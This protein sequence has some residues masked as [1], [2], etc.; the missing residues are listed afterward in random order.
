ML[1]AS[2]ASAQTVS[3]ALTFGQNNFYG[4]ARTLAMGNAVTAV[5]GDM[6][7]ISIN[8]AGGAVSAFSQFSFSTGWSTSRSSSSYAPSYDPTSQSAVYDGRFENSKTRMTIPNI[9][10]NLY[11]ETGERSG[12][13]G[14]NFGFM[15]NR[16]QTYTSKMGASGLEGH[17]S[18][19]GALACGADGM[20]GNILGNNNMF[21]TD[22]PW[23]SICAYDGG[24]I[25][26]NSDAGTYYGSAETVTPPATPADDYR[27]EVLGTLRQNI[28]TTTLGSKNDLVMNYGVNIDDRLF[29]GLSMNCPIVSYKYSEYFNEAV[30]DPDEFKITTEYFDKTANAYVKGNPTSYTG[31]TYKYNYIADVS[32]INLKIGAIW[33]PTDGLRLGAAFQ[34]PTGYTINETWYVDVESRFLDAAQNANSSSPTAKSSYSYRAP[35][36]ANFG[37]AYT[38][39]RNGMLSVDYELTDY[40]IMKFSM[41]EGDEYVYSDP[42]YA[43]NK[44]NKLF[45]GVSHALRV[46]AEFRVLPSVS[47]RAGLN[48]VTSAERHYTNS[49]G[50][51]VYVADYDAF[52]NDYQNGTLSI[53]KSTAEY[54]DDKLFTLSCGIGYSSPGSFY[55]DLA[56]RHS[57]LP[58][59]YYR[60]YS[61]YLNIVSPAVRSKHTLFDAVMTF[62]WRF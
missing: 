29:L 45:C 2:L 53:D 10:M 25:N 34:T 46:G 32:G 23:N 60:P 42:F 4:T 8:P 15:V 36:S 54:S 44:L 26:F 33:L 14:W 9:G 43:V 30:Q 38:L 12:V 58:D 61:N 18:M 3:D 59:S 21:D 51:Q 13:K 62:G 57:N 40:S 11:F 49:E 19:T 27:Y 55:A 31:S 7:S 48:Y 24:L 6:G 22:Y 16:S 5:G 50:D 41:L 17:T 56:F 52:F 20:P 1:I 28:G 39:G 35:Y 47:L 37:V